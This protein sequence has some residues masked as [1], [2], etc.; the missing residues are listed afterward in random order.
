M[1]TEYMPDQI[2]IFDDLKKNENSRNDS[3]I[4]AKESYWYN[5]QLVIIQYRSQEGC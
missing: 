1:N 3:L 4:F 5:F 2:V